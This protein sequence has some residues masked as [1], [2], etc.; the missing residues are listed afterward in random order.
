VEDIPN[1]AVAKAMLGKTPTVRD[2]VTPSSA[3]PPTA[4]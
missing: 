3:A 1:D 4:G 2:V